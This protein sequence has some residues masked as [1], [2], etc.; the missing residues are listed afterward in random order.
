MVLFILEKGSTCKM[1]GNLDFNL[2][3]K[4]KNIEG[5]KVKIVELLKEDNKKSPE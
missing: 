2:L 4:N 3:L 1:I 5:K